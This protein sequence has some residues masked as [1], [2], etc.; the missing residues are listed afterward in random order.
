MRRSASAVFLA[1][2]LLAV[3]YAT[4]S[5]APLADSAAAWRVRWRP[6]PGDVLRNFVLFVPLGAAWAARGAS[7]RSALL[8][9]L[10]LSA[11]LEL[12]QLG[13]PGRYGSPWDALG[14]TLGAGCGA[15]LAREARRWLAPSR[16]AAQRLALAAGALATGSLLLGGWIAAPS[17]PAGDYFA[18]WTPAMAKWSAT[19]T[20]LR[21]ASL[22]GSPLPHG[23]LADSDALRRALAGDFDLRLAALAGRPTA[24]LAA[25]LWLTNQGGHEVLLVG[26]EGSDLILRWPGRGAPLGLE[27]PPLRLPE[28]LAQLPPGA[29]FELLLARRGAESCV[30]LGASRTCGLGA[31]AGDGWRVLAP[32]LRL[33]PGL[34]EGL[35]AAW[36][37][38]LWLP[39]G[40]WFTPS[41]GPL[42]ALS[43]TGA[44]TLFTPRLGSLLP[45]PPSQLIAAA[46]GFFLGALLRRVWRAR[47]AV[48]PT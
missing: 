25:L 40:F 27:L 30:V 36:I 12:A 20:S 35:A 21:A 18:H 31:S 46:L 32:E 47:E 1:A 29:P 41:A 17:P 7:A 28:R 13:I 8:G 4:L 38:A 2:A 48:V 43:M 22:G 6:A 16:A 19:D 15:R 23:A 42:L 10:A 39:L 44:A 24:D 34:R 33:P 14:N 9:A 11:L 26:V 37:G 3:L 45:T 5:P